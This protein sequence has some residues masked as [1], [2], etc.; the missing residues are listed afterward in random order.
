MSTQLLPSESVEAE[1]E[2]AGEEEE[3]NGF[4]HVDALVIA[5]YQYGVPSAVRNSVHG[6]F[7]GEGEGDEEG[8]G[9]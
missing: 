2:G 1:R 3:E 7:E 5:L 4:S 9:N 6:P 8:K